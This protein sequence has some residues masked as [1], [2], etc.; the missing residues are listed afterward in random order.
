LEENR[1]RLANHVNHKRECPPGFK[2]NK[3]TTALAWNE[4][5]TSKK[6]HVDMNGSEDYAGER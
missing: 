3:T 5:S 1:A 6:H 4:T 2:N